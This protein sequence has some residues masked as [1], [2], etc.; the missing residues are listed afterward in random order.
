MNE[1]TPQSL[2]ELAVEALER[3]AF[4]LA[5]P[6][7]GEGQDLNGF[8]PALGFAISFAGLGEGN[9]IL[10]ADEDFA[11]ELAAGF[12]GAEPE[13]VDVP[14]HGRDAVSE[15]TNIVGG[16]VVLTLGGDQHEYK[17]GLPEPF[18][19]E[20]WPTCCDGATVAVL[21]GELGR[22]AIVCRTVDAAQKR[23][24]A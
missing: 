17:Y 23:S 9:V 7:E 3:I 16:S 13:E 14:T 11:A 6:L 12:L 20:G 21:E 8:A 5:T 10:I 19:L 15:L 4:V 2:A 18:D 22:L 1:L 24:A